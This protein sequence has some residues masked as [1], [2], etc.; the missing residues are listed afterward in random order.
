MKTTRKKT[1]TVKVTV[2]ISE[3]P[4][5]SISFTLKSLAKGSMT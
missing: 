5:L 4:F 1:W 2:P 3:N